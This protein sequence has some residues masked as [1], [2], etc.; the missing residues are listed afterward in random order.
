MPMAFRGLLIS[1]L[2]S[3]TLRRVINLLKLRISF[4]L[5]RLLRKPILWGLPFAASIEPTTSC[6]LGCPEC[7]SGLRQFSRPTGSMDMA[8]FRRI[9]DELSPTLAYLTLYFQGEPY[10]NPHFFHFVDYA[11]RKRIFTATSTNAHFLS[12]RNAERTVQSGL[13]RL[14]ISLDGADADSYDRYRIGGDY[15]KVLA[16][17]KNLVDAKKK[18][19]SQK[20]FLELQF[21]VFRHNEEQIPQIKRLATE[22]GVDRLNLKSA[23][24]YDFKEG[25]DFIPASGQFA[26]YRKD[27]NGRWV[28]KSKLPNSCQRMWQG[29]VITWDG[30]VVPC[31]FD[32][33]ARYVMGNIL[34]KSFAEIWKSEGYSAF[35]RQLFRKR[36][37]ID[38]C[39]NCSEGLKL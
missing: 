17:V 23:Q 12:P 29:M 38:I 10:L 21:I 4:A 20:P 34:E 16:G 36:S 26:R 3:I 25:S 7:P 11:S 13:D 33:D 14:I 32:K 9:C 19:G 35:R 30:R 2:R 18:L 1:Y 24:I 37:S 39:S 31:C 28:I 22:L 8:S 15:N 6:N 27:E 5:S